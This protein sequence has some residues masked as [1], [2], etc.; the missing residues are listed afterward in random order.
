[1]EHPELLCDQND[2]ICAE[3]QKVDNDKFGTT[4]RLLKTYG[5]TITTK[6]QLDKWAVIYQNLLSNS[7]LITTK[8]ECLELLHGL[9]SKLVGCHVNFRKSE[10]K[11]IPNKF[12]CKVHEYNNDIILEMKE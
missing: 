7:G 6:E 5:N 4:L 9:I 10:Y 2:K 8:D 1:M 12:C 3:L 11:S